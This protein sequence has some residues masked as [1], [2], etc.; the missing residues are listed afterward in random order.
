MCMIFNFIV[1]QNI[2]FI[3]TMDH[4]DLN[5]FGLMISVNNS[6][7]T[8]LSVN[9]KIENI[10]LHF[11]SKINSIQVKIN[12]IRIFCAILQNSV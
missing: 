11:S 8:T 10:L 12:Y 2:S 4:E 7:F 1:V 3:L 9:K 5:S 6:G